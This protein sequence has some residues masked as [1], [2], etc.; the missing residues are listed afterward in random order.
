MVEDD[1]RFE[2]RDSAHHGHP[3]LAPLEAAEGKRVLAEGS[4][5]FHSPI[6]AG[7][8]AQRPGAQGTRAGPHTTSTASQGQSRRRGIG[9]TRANPSHPGHG[10]PAIGGIVGIASIE[11]SVYKYIASVRLA[12]S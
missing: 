7:P 5:N 9:N 12:L 8:Q 11:D 10:M 2:A 6:L 4:R 3:A 1:A